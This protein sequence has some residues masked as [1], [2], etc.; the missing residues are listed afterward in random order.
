MGRTVVRRE[1]SRVTVTPT[2]AS[3][4]RSCIIYGLRI[5]RAVSR[6]LL[7]WIWRELVSTVGWMYT[8]FIVHSDIK[9]ENILLTTKPPDSLPAEVKPLVKLIEA[10]QA[11][12]R[13]PW[14]VTRCS[15]RHYV[16]SGFLVAA[17]TAAAS[18]LTPMRPNR[19]Q[20]YN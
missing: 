19:H 7:P 17:Y 14:L 4:P 11:R 20:R 13:R 2:H 12:H 1:E 6:S 18:P 15:S 9:F 10:A 3:L 16:A 8:R 5:P